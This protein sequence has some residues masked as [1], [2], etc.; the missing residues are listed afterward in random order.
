LKIEGVARDPEDDKLLACAVE[1]RADYLVSGDKDLLVLQ[2][3]AGVQVISP[4]QFVKI[5]GE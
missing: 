4:A 2:E 5:L 1:G 3:Y